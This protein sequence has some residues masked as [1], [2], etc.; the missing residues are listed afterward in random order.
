MK[1][2]ALYEKDPARVKQ[3]LHDSDEL[4]KKAE[5][6]RLKQSGEA[7]KGSGK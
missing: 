7:A 4:G 3:L 6:L 1:Q 5:T 2:Q